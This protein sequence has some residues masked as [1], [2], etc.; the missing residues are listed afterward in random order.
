MNIRNALHLSTVA[1]VLAGGTSLMAQI[2]TGALNGQVTDEAGNPIVGAKVILE[3]P[4]LF[5]P[6]NVVTD[7]KGEYRAL[8]LPVGN[9]VVKVSAAGKLGKTAQDVRVGVGSNLSLPFTL[10]AQKADAAAATVEV[11]STSVSES[12]TDDKVAVNYSAEQLMQLP[13]GLNFESAIQLAPGVTGYGTGAQIRGSG[14]NQI[15]YRV[16]GINVQDSSGSRTALYTPLQDTIEDV[17]VVLSALNARNGLVQGGQMNMVTKSGS[18][19][20]EGTVRA[21]MSR[22]SWSADYNHTDAGTNN[23]LLNEDFNRSVDFFVSGPILKDRLWFALAATSKPSEPH[24]NYFGYTA[25][26]ILKPGSALATKYNGS[27]MPWSDIY[28]PNAIKIGGTGTGAGLA[29]YLP[30]VERGVL[31]PMGTYGLYPNVDQVIYQ[32]PG[33]GYGVNLSDVGNYLH[34]TNKTQHYQLKLTGMVNDAHVVSATYL[35]HK[36]TVGSGNGEH[37]DNPWMMVTKANIGD[38]VT[39]TKAWT[40]N[41]NGNLAS[42]WTIEA[43]VYQAKLDAA[44]VVNPNPGVSVMG[45]FASSDPSIMLHELPNNTGHDWV[46]FEDGFR[47]GTIEDHMSSY[48]LPERHGNKAFTANLKTFQEWNGQHEIDF[49]M[50]SVTTVYNFGRSKTGNRAVFQGGWYKDG[51]GNTLYPVFHR[52]DGSEILNRNIAATPNGLSLW[53]G[54][55]GGNLDTNNDKFVHWSDAMRGPSAHMEQYWNQSSDS[56]N[57]TTSAWLND[58]WQINSNWNVLLGVRFNK[59]KLEDEGGREIVSSTMSEPRAQVKFNPD[60]KNKEVWSFSIAKLAS[61]YSDQISNQFRGNEW[62]VRTVH[63]WSGANLPG[64]Q[65]GI[66]SAAAAT[67]STYGVRFV[68]YTQLT[69]PK[70]YGAAT[71]LFNAPQNFQALN[72]TAPYTIEFNLGYQRNYETG[73]VKINA[74]KRD[75][76]NAIVSSIRD[77]GYD[78]LVTMT[79]PEPGSS[80]EKVKGRVKWFNSG[81]TQ[82]FNSIELNWHKQLTSKLSFDGS[83]TWS[84]MTGY[85]DFEYYNWKGLRETPGLLT[86]AQQAAAISD[87]YLSKDRTA[88]V[89]FTYA[90]P[91]GKGNVSFTLKADT[92]TGGVAS[93]VGYG[94]YTMQPNWSNVAINTSDARFHGLEVQAVENR[95]GGRSQLWYAQYSGEMGD[96]KSGLD[97][98]QVTARVQAEIPIGLGKTRLVSYFDIANLFNHA[99]LTNPYN[100]FTGDALGDPSSSWKGTINGRQNMWFAKPHGSDPNP[101]NNGAWGNGGDAGR[102]NIGTFSIG[103]KF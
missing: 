100:F 101:G 22:S 42:N 44:D 55:A 79:S 35:Y 34:T 66:D 12:K 50:E 87:G 6:R 28:G 85:N 84:Q 63:R 17:Q 32:G 8:L 39:T 86:S 73:Y 48:N 37:S 88:H 69:D 1:V 36:D 24:T 71:D 64:G 95:G 26:G 77:Y 19:V 99:I 83:Y 56:G 40:L 98:Y 81:N 90:Q 30:G 76:K 29:T 89:W 21:Y 93:I 18:N 57:N 82:K 9:Y 52:Q 51:S 62:E 13:I 59:L 68:N 91:V 31:E 27:R 103:L 78:E 60:G 33:G 25:E 74:V 67:D 11:V 38:N 47:Y 10:K 92:W 97:Y 53:E 61:A 23:S 72:L 49:G 75:Y 43:R 54:A 16:D 5:Q 7:A 46:Q 65:P 70:N 20:F 102:R 14:T 45:Y 41:W 94:D 15:M 4:A 80:Y 2:T 58:V 96:Y 3:S